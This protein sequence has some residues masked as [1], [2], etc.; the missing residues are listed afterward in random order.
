M[1]VKGATGDGAITQLLTSHLCRY[2][3]ILSA[4]CKACNYNATVGTCTS[5][6]SPCPQALS[7]PAMEF[8]I[9]TQKPYEQCY[10]WIPY[11]P[12]YSEDARMIY[13]EHSSRIIGR[14]QRANNNVVC[15]FHTYFK[16]C[17]GYFGSTFRSALC[18]RLRIAE[19]CTIHWVP[20]IAR[21]PIPHRA[22][23]AGHMAN[24]DTVYV[25]KFE[26]GNGPLSGLPGHYVEGAENT[27]SE[28]MNVPRRST[29]MMMMVVLWTVTTIRGQAQ[30]SLL[31]R[32]Y[33]Q[34]SYRPSLS[35]RN[36]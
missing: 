29:T 36:I 6:N 8:A 33:G 25:S 27:V 24:G 23:T 15:Y 9:F 30:Q 34:R 31:D 12:G 3:C 4:T 18:Q 2:R 35:L 16:D 17:F 20:Y 32:F 11:S 14:T 28:Y 1:L 13:T 26:V 5:Y 19:G 10:E 7:D 21:D 22:V